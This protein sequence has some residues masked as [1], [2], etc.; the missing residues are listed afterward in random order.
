MSK[1][2]NLYVPFLLGIFLIGLF[3]APSPSN[4][5]TYYWDT[6]AGVNGTGGTG[7]FTT[8]G[9]T[10][11]TDPAGSATL[12]ANA[13]TTNDIANFQGTAGTVTF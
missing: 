4:A 7:T 10:W 5:V 2:L 12:V 11:S 13:G 8:S 3:S 1:K 9:A 6:L